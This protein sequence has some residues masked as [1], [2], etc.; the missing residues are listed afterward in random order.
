[1]TYYS[2]NKMLELL[3][4]KIGDKKEYNLVLHIAKKYGQPE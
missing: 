4:H 1:M 2:L 3:A